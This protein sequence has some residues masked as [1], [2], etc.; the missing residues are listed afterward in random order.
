VEEKKGQLSSEEQEEEEELD[1]LSEE[2]EIEPRSQKALG[3]KGKAIRKTAKTSELIEIDS[4]TLVPKA[5]SDEIK[6]WQTMGLSTDESKAISK[7]Y[8]LEFEDQSFSFKPPSS[9][10]TC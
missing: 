2:G 8:A 6:V 3:G 9:T 7:K 10:I 5:I 4:P 1:I